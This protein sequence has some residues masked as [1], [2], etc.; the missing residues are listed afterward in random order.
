[1]SLLTR[2]A[3]RSFLPALIAL[4]VILPVGSVVSA[5]AC[6]PICPICTGSGSNTEAMLSSRTIFAGV[7]FFQEAE[8]TFVTNLKLAL[9]SRFDVGFGYLNLSRE[10]IWNARALLLTEKN[11]WPAVIAGIGS[12]KANDLPPVIDTTPELGCRCQ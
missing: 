4:M 12:V 9:S 3:G 10:V 5:Q 11:G 1:M 7:L 6:G 2:I 8:E